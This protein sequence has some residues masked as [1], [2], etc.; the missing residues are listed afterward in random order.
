[1]R[2]QCSARKLVEYNPNSQIAIIYHIGRHKCHEKLDLQ[3]RRQNLQARTKKYAKTGATA[4]QASKLAVGNLIMQGKAK[5]ES[6][7]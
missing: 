2:E 4:T 6:I 1:M 3:L 7:A 5:E